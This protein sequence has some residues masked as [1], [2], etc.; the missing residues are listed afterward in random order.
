MSNQNSNQSE[1]YFYRLLQMLARMYLDLQQLRIA[2]EHR[3]RRIRMEA[4]LI[5]Y[6]EINGFEVLKEKEK[7]KIMNEQKQ[8]GEQQKYWK[9]VEK[10]LK[11]KELLDTVNKM[12]DDSDAMITMTAHHTRLKKEEKALLK[13]SGGVFKKH[14]LWQYCLTVKGLGPVACMTFLGYI[15]P[16]VADTVGKFWAYIGLIPGARLEAGKK[17]HYSPELKGRFWVVAC[18]NPIMAK[19]P[20]YTELY[21]AKKLYLTNREDLVAQKDKKGWKGHVDSMA[22]RWMEKL[23][24]GHAWE[25]IRKTERLSINPHHSYIPLKPKDKLMMAKILSYLCE[26]I[27]LNKSVEYEE[28]MRNLRQLGYRDE[29]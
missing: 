24:I 14:Q 1:S 11:E 7:L 17:A 21:H 2:V 5:K 12:V 16:Y 3:M 25:I 4:W 23:V 10:T 19:D 8:K 15:N 26:S 13:E 27:K 9:N 29:W 20:Y 6:C 18:R 28:Q 22:K